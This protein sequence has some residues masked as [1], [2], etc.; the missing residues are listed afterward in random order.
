MGT[1]GTGTATDETAGR[2][3]ASWATIPNAVTVLRLLILVPVCWS[4]ID[5]G[6]DSLSVVLL[7]IWASTDWIDGFLARALNQTSRV[8]QVLDPVADRLGVAAI[9][10]SLAFGQLV[11]WSVLIVI[12]ATDVLTALLAGRAALRG[13][14]SVSWLGKVRTAVLMTG[15]LLLATV[16]VWAPQL[17]DLAVALVWLGAGLHVLAGLDYIAKVG[18]MR[19]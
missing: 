9:I 5:G 7:L 8:G 15:L 16:D 1:H 6:P 18:R 14:I 4:L 19:R 10:L 12:A 2:R 17:S 13:R 3:D 11:P